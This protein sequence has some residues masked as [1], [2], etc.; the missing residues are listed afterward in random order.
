MSSQRPQDFLGVETG[1]RGRE[2]L[3]CLTDAAQEDR[4]EVKRPCPRVFVELTAENPRDEKSVLLTSKQRRQIGETL[5]GMLH[6]DQEALR[7]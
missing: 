2:L 7:A 6:L 3:G 5:L 1:H 4:L